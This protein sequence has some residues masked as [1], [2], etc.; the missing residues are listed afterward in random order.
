[1][2]AMELQPFMKRNRLSMSLVVYML[3]MALPVV[4]GMDFDMK[5]REVSISSGSDE[6]N[7]TAKVFQYLIPLRYNNEHAPLYLPEKKLLVCRTPKV[8]S[9]YLRSVFKAYR[10]NRTYTTLLNK[11]ILPRDNIL[12]SRKANMTVL[13]GNDTERILFVRDPLTRTLAGYLEMEHKPSPEHFRKW[14]NSVFTREYRD[15]CDTKATRLSMDPR[16]QHWTPAQFCRCGL[17]QF[18]VPFRI[19]KIERISPRSVLRSW[20]DNKY[21]GSNQSTHSRS[22]NASSYLT[23][24]VTAHILNITARERHYFEYT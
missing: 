11:P 4:V 15:I 17:E 13:F 24:A 18:H 7:F 6:S 22:Y 23:P 21:L 14:A 12:I 5:S 2:I 8:G 19:L 1:M 10:E 16:R 20:F 9:L 3:V